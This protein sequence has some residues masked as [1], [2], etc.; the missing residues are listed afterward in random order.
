V[1]PAYVRIS[2]TRRAEAEVAKP[3]AVAKSDAVGNWR[4]LVLGSTLT[5]RDPIN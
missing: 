5:A 3:V 2:P 4:A 1:N